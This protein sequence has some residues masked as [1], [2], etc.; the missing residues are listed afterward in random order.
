MGKYGSELEK[1]ILA[2]LSSVIKQMLTLTFEFCS[3]MGAHLVSTVSL[4]TASPR[5]G[6]SHSR[7]MGA[8]WPLETTAIKK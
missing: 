5:I 3:G 4:L 2:L 7:N 1:V 6:S 8:R